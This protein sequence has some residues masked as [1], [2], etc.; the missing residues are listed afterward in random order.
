MRSVACISKWRVDGDGHVG[1][2]G[3]GQAVAR[4]CMPDSG[5][6]VHIQGC[7]GAS[8]HLLLSPLLFA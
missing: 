5:V 7:Q 3:M 6:N 4:S 2:D 8:P 1:L